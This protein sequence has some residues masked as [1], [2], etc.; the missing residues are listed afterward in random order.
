MPGLALSLQSLQSLQWAPGA[1]AVLAV[2]QAEDRRGAQ[3][4]L[5][6]ELNVVRDQGR[7]EISAIQMDPDA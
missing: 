5:A 3:Y 2:V 7:W 6:Y 1:S 4:T